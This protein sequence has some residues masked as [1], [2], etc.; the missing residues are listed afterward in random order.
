[1]NLLQI[2]SERRKIVLFS[3]LVILLVILLTRQVE[4]IPPGPA[5]RVIRTIVHP[6]VAALAAAD[7]RVSYAWLI[8]FR[9]RDLEAE[10]RELRQELA[11]LRIRDQQ[12]AEDHARLERLS[13]LT[14]RWPA[15]NMP[16]VT[17]NI[18]GFSSNFWT[19]SVTIDRGRRDKVGPD[20]PVVNQDGLVGIVR[21]AT[22]NEALVQLL[23]DPEFA[24]GALVSETRDRGII[25][26]TGRPDRLLLV[27]ENPQS[28]L[29]EGS[30]V[31]TSGLPVGS[32]FPKGFVIGTI[33]GI[34]QSKFG[35]PYVVKPT[36]RFDRLEEV[37][38]LLEARRGELP[39]QQLP[40][41]PP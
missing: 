15:F 30:Q 26:G 14:A 9:S 11:L 33:Q 4:L 17:A 24:A 6:L 25:E 40:I 22:D 28:S 37:V 27:L 5:G 29:K 31:M 19:R 32:L 39:P 34:E 7:S 38:V 35:Q 18:V 2:W 16:N 21:E 13:G 12:L 10:N 1:M 23:I 20:M 41:P 3:L 8:L 36:V